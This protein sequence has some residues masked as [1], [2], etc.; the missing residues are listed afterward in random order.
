[1]PVEME[2]NLILNAVS[3]REQVRTSFFERNGMDIQEYLEAVR[4]VVPQ[5]ENGSARVRPTHREQIMG[6]LTRDRYTFGYDV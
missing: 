1:M 5:Q 4:T 3:A 2:F 6:Q